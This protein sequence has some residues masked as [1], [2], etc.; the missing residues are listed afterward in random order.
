[1]DDRIPVVTPEM[2]SAVSETIGITRG[3]HECPE[4]QDLFPTHVKHE[5][6][7]VQQLLGRLL[8]NG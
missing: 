6:I 2:L 4:L 3:L 1:M 7:N 5:L 8:A